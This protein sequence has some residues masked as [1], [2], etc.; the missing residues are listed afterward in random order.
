M[1]FG[2][3]NVE[4]RYYNKGIRWNKDTRKEIQDTFVVRYLPLSYPERGGKMQNNKNDPLLAELREDNPPPTKPA[5]RCTATVP[6]ILTAVVFLVLFAVAYP[7]SLGIAY[8][9][10]KL[11]VG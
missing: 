6:E 7:A 8:L 2:V 1:K 11:F 5:K 4:L 9:V 3:D 10:L